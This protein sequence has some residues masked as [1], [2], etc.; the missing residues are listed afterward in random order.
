[1]K[2]SNFEFLESEFPILFNI[3]QSAEYN[4][5]ED[6]NTTLVKL[7]Q[8]GE[9]LTENVFELHG[10]EFPYE[11]TFNNRLKRLKLQRILPERIKDLLYTLKNTGN[12]AAHQFTGTEGEAKTA[13]F[14]SFKVGKWFYQ[15]YAK[16]ELDVSNLKFSKPEKLDARHALYVLEEDYKLL[17][18]K[19]QNLLENR[20]IGPIAEEVQ[21]AYAQ[22]A[23]KAASKVEMNEEE[24]RVFIDQQLR[25]A[26]WE[27]DTQH[28]NYK[29]E[30]TLPEK[31]R[32]MAIAE[33]RC[34]TLWADYALFIGTELV[35][36]VE[37][38]KH[39]KNVMSDL[40]QAKKYSAVV[41]EKHDITFPNHDN[42]SNYK[43]PF[44]FSTNGKPF[45][46]QFKAASGIWFWDA[47]NQ[48]N[49]ARPLRNWFSP[50][51]LKEKLLFDETQGETNLKTDGY[52]LLSDPDGLS[53]RDYQI[54][55]IKAVENKILTDSEDRRALLAM[56]TGTGKT[57]TM[58]GMCY[59]LIKAKRFRRILF[60]VD[61]RMLG[62]QAADNFKE[63]KVEN[64][65]TFAQI[66]DLQ[67]LE[68]KAAELDTKIQFATVQSLVQRIV[69][70]DNPPSIGDFDCIVVDEAHRGYTLDKEMDKEEFI[71]RDQKDFQSKYRMV[72]DY[73]DAYRI[74]LTA[75]P[76]V[77][78]AEIFGKPVFNYSY[79]RAVV[80]GYLIDFEPPYVFQTTLS[81]NG[82][83][84]KKGDPVKVYDPE[85][86]VIAD[87]GIA[88]DEITVEVAGFNKKVITEGFNRAIINTL[89]TEY[90]LDPQDRKKTLIFTANNTH[91]DTVVRLLYEEYN[92]LGEPVDADAIVKITGEVYDRENILRKFKNDQFPS[93]VVTV[94]LLTTGIDVPSICN[95]VF[96]RRVNSRILYDQMIGRATRKCDE[97]GKEI[98]KIYDCVGVSEIMESEDVMKPVSPLVTK[99]FA[100]LN[101]ELALIEDEYLKEAKLDRII[102]KLHRKYRSLNGTQ[103]EQF[104]TLSKE[105]DASSLGQKLKGTDTDQLNK[106]IADYGH[107]WEFLDREKGKAH[108]FSTLWSDEADEVEDVKR[109]YGK[110]LKPKDYIESF[111]DFIKNNQNKYD[112]LHII[113]TKPADLTRKELKELRL[114]L[115]T[116]GFNKTNLNTAYNELKNENIVADII[117]HIRTQAL[118]TD[119]I[120]HKDRISNAVEKLKTQKKWNAIQLRWLDKIKAQ[121]LKETIVKV[122]DLDKPPFSLEGG[123]KRMNKAFNNETEDIIS[124]LNELLYA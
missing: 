89:I 60:L 97:I 47:R 21:S 27:C 7:R 117:G 99:S 88:E 35:G 50:T 83:Q 93:I 44:T 8:F 25:D 109:A 22:R 79:R 84:W 106:T 64:L 3:G 85:A 77:H 57:R 90:G 100:D 49:I 39:I 107:L 48:T 43:V 70:S 10:L 78:T 14:S 123:L 54:E 24:T 38:K 45:L 92:A 98:F 104:R 18:E 32:Q 28:L 101:E 29:T 37:A 113:C 53:L 13:L 31:G 16:D 86:N 41:E 103:Q 96:L 94:D 74:G 67:D 120:N 42:S 63:V 58:I 91:A 81:K 105:N 95:L 118:G 121:L 114:I 111:T 71:L 66:Y 73:F 2:Q 52:E 20:T 1:M 59:R 80:E 124:E 102:A 15:T 115:D 87:A 26:G 46:E 19:F 23:K 112:A 40:G 12:S 65:Q 30:K 72:L 17:E 5:F 36:I 62:S 116:V 82:I 68:D 75:T 55:A 6:P 110:R 4:L 69:Y 9:R 11:N 51:D 108:N 56:A 119:L 34:G 76:A 33:W 61:R 122:E